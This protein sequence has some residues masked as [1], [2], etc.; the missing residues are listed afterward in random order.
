MAC[1]AVVRFDRVAPFGA[2][3]LRALAASPKMPT[4][5]D[6]S[7]PRFAAGRCWAFG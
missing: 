4:N 5:D 6:K 3:P 7:M 1:K 2:D